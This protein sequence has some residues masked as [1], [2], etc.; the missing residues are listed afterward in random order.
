[1]RTFEIV[2][3]QSAIWSAMQN[4]IQ[5]FALP[6][7]PCTVAVL[8]DS[9]LR[10]SS[11]SEVLRLLSGKLGEARS[12]VASCKFLFDKRLQRKTSLTSVTAICYALLLANSAGVE[13]ISVPGKLFLNTLVLICQVIQADVFAACAWPD[14]SSAISAEA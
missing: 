7:L 9:G 1:V 10:S 14:R 2:S 8:T 5:G 6:C 13:S 11:F 3:E 12:A 4:A